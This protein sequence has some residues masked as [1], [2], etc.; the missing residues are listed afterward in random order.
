MFNCMYVD[1]D[2]D[3]DISPAEELCITKTANY[4]TFTTDICHGARKLATLL[5]TVIGNHRYYRVKG[6]PEDEINQYLIKTCM[7]ER[8][9]NATHT[10]VSIFCIKLNGRRVRPHVFLVRSHHL[11]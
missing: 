5:T 9:S 2:I 1:T 11:L 10:V 6:M 3:D 8:R 4:G 7:M